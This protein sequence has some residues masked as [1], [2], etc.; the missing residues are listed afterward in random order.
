MSDIDAQDPAV[1]HK[2]GWVTRSPIFYGWIILLAGT[3]GLVMASPGQTHAISIFVDHFIEDLHLSRSLVSTL[4]TLGTLLAS[5][6]LPLVGQQI[7]R[8]GPRLMVVAIATLFGLACIYMSFVR[9][10]VMLGV[11]FFAVRTLGNGSLVLVSQNVINRW[12]VRRRGTMMGIAGMGVGLLGFGGSPILVNELIPTF[13]WRLTYVLLGLGV[14]FVMLPLSFLLFRD[15]PEDYGLRPDGKEPRTVDGDTA[16]LEPDEEHWR[17]REALRTAAFWAVALGIAS[18]WMMTSGLY[19]HIVSVLADN[20][21]TSAVAATVFVPIALSA[22]MVNLVGGILVDR[23]PVRVL[24]ATALVLQALTLAVAQFLRGV[25]MAFLYGVIQGAA[26]GL[27]TVVN[28]VVW[29]AYFGRRHLG[30]I[31]GA[32]STILIAGSAL[33]P[34]PLGIARDLLGN[35]NLALTVSATVPLLLGIANLL[36]KRPRKYA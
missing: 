6:P 18:T 13:G 27:S 29:A 11:G 31:A 25:E 17:P 1:L 35:Y 26:I 14:L 33:G 7:D 4:Y 21:L 16:P 2:R 19:F 15:Q 10:A 3:L 22:T 30:S 5:L 20:G 23:L 9:S 8:R 34:M 24:M 36:V 32:A 12:W 28:N